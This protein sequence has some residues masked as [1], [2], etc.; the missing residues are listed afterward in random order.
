MALNFGLGTRNLLIKNYA[1]AAVGE[2]LGTFLFLFLAYVAV[3]AMQSTETEDPGLNSS[4]LL[5][6]SFAFGF[7]LCINVWIF[8]R[9]SGGIFNP[10]VTWACV[11]LGL[12][13]I[14][15]GVLLSV[16]QIL[17]G[18]VAAAGAKAIVPVP[19]AVVVGLGENTSTTQGFFLETIL[20]AELTLAILFL[21]VEKHRATPFAPLV[22]GFTL[23]TCHLVGVPFTG[24]SLN[25]ARAFGPAV[26]AGLFEKS[27][28]IYWFGPTL[29]AG[30][31]AGFY[32]LLKFSNYKTANLGQDFD[33]DLE[34]EALSK[35]AAR[36]AREEP[37]GPDQNVPIS[38]KN[39]GRGIP[40]GLI[41]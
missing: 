38:V 24:A 22:I 18:I 15:K 20:T 4:K 30:I 3:S 23:F 40:D 36:D 5:F 16:A 8:Y 28:W 21:A 35:A 14:G 39:N 9:I 32:R 41:V 11:L 2:F 7:S 31:A 13:P 34:S 27:H 17:G 1:I 6:I 12:M 33:R 29:G 26:V 25:P 10:S 19:L 37:F